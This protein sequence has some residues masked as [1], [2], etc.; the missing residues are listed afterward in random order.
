MIG[1]VEGGWQW[2]WGGGEGGGGGGWGVEVGGGGGGRQGLCVVFC[3]GFARRYGPSV[4][5]SVSLSD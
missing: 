2:W 5:H 1:W 3:Q 4:F